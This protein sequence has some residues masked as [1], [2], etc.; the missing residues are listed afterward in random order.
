MGRASSGVAA[1]Y[2]WF[3]LACFFPGALRAADMAN[4]PAAPEPVVTEIRFVGN[5]TTKPQI[6]LEEMQV[7]VGDRA[8]PQLI[9]RSRQAIMDLGLFK[10]VTSELVPAQG[11]VVLVVTVAEKYYFLPI[12]RLGHDQNYHITWGAQV[13]WDNVAGLNQSLDITDDAEKA[14]TA[15]GKMTTLSFDYSYPRIIGTPYQIDFNSSRVR[16]PVRTV[17]NGVATGYQQE[18]RTTA[19][20]LSRWFSPQG[21]TVGLRAGGGMVWRNLDNQVG[22]GDPTGLTRGKAVG[23]SVVLENIRVHNYVYSR[24]GRDFGYNGE[25][26]VTLLGSDNKYTRHLFYYREYRTMFGRP[27]HTLEWQLQLGLSTSALLGSPYTY[28]LGGGSSL[29]GYGDGSV[30]GNAFV[31]ANVQYLRPLFGYNQLRGAVFT[32]IGNA[33]PRNSAIDFSGLKTSVGMGLRLKLK[34]LVNV[35]LRL[36]VAYGIDSHLT[37]IYASSSEMF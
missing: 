9:E 34:S 15:P 27:Y 28:A 24:A 29:R 30:T 3:L 8:D 25:F 31:L 1:A 11:G 18:A 19:F 37:K 4:A 21:P 23:V 2:T 7:R 26:G 32:D 5:K 14:P 17:N 36:D 16:T 6:M 33:Y 35:D 10:S 12:P 22:F 13:R 20:T